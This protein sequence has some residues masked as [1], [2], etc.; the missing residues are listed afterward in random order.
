MRQPQ[1]VFPLGELQE[2]I[3]RRDWLKSDSGDYFAVIGQ[4]FDR[5]AKS[6]EK[7]GYGSFVD[8]KWQ[9]SWRKRSGYDNTFWPNAA[10][11]EWR[12]EKGLDVPG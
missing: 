6:L 12:K 3:L 4:G 5:A 7:K 8:N 1:K 9:Y 2:S 10:A 11:I